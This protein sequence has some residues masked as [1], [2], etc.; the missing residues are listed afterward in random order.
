MQIEAAK[1]FY[2]ITIISAKIIKSSNKT[3]WE[4]CGKM[5]FSYTVGGIK[6]YQQLNGICN[7]VIKLK[8]NIAYNSAIPLQVTYPN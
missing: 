5:E 1:N 3:F 6:N 7:Y 8:F 4:A 2:F